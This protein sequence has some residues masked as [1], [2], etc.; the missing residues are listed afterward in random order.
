MSDV[1]R[2]RQFVAFSVAM[3]I[4]GLTKLLSDEA[5]QAIKECDIQAYNGR[6]IAIDASMAIY[7]FLVRAAVASAR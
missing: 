5:P 2:R 6:K 3:G 4:K 1:A 7:G